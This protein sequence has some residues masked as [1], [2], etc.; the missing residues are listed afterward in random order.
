MRTARSLT[1][2]CRIWLGGDLPKPPLDAHPQGRSLPQMHT[3]CMQ[4]SLGKPSWMQPPLRRNPSLWTEGTT[5]A[6]ENITFPQLLLPV[7]DPAAG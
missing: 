1:V 4:T 6:Y 3:P 2:S 5:H 7:T